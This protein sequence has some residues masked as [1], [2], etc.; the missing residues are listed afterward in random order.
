VCVAPDLARGIADYARFV[1]RHTHLRA[2]CEDGSI[3]AGV[4]HVHASLSP[5]EP[6]AG[7]MINNL[8]RDAV[9]RAG[10]R[11]GARERWRIG[12]PYVG[13]DVPVLFVRRPPGRGGGE[14]G[15]NEPAEA[16]TGLLL[17][18][19]PSVPRP[20]GFTAAFRLRA[21]RRAYPPTL[22]LDRVARAI[23]AAYVAIGEVTPSAAA[24]LSLTPRPGGIVRC[25]LS[26][27]NAAENAQ[28][29]ASLDEA[30]SPATGQRYVISRPVWPAEL[31]L[32]AA[33]WR[34]LTGRSPLTVAWHAV[35]SDF[36]SKKER[37]ETYRAAWCA[38]V[39]PGQLLFAGREAAAGRDELVAAA[40]TRADYV[41]SRRTLWH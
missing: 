10:D 32:G 11:D 36:S 3:E 12:E 13:E 23:V 17:S 24:S 5:Y 4:S 40:A 34:A 2:P 33:R 14:G 1:R 18:T 7:D 21:L 8:N 38:N 6:P 41:T 15:D 9:T 25:A 31:T 30:L 16:D 19:P 26:A 22:P 39:G 27:G 29:T 20:D 37:A 28:L 35:P